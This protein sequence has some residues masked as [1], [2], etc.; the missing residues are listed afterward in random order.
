MPRPKDRTREPVGK[1]LIRE[2]LRGIQQSAAGPPKTTAA[3]CIFHARHT[4][5]PHVNHK[6]HVLPLGLGGPDVQDNEVVVCPTMHAN[7]HTILDRAVKLS[8]F[9][10]WEFLKRFGPADRQIARR[11]WDAFV[12]SLA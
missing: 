6:H 11:G 7:I 8:T 1:G 3:P 5:Q 12:A 10:P 4:P 9:P 2:A